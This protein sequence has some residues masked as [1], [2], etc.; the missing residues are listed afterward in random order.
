VKQYLGLL[1]FLGLNALALLVGVMLMR[2]TRRVQITVIHRHDDD[3]DR[4]R[5]PKF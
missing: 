2:V 4:R 1:V 3:D 5:D